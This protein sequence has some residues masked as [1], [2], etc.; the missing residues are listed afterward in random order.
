MIPKAL[1]DVSIEDIKGL[2]GRSEHQRLEFKGWPQGIE[3]P[4]AP[5]RDGGIPDK[6]K[7]YLAEEVCAM[8]NSYGGDIVLGLKEGEGQTRHIAEAL[9]PL[10]AVEKLKKVFEDSLRNLIDPPLSAIDM[11]TIVTGEDGAGVLLIR[12]GR[13]HR[14]P[15][16]VRDGNRYAV[17]V[18]S[19]EGK[20]PVDMREVQDLVIERLSSE[21][22]KRAAFLDIRDA[23]SVLKGSGVDI[24]GIL[25]KGFAVRLVA[26][27][28]EPLSISDI[29]RN[30]AYRIGPGR[31]A[32]VSKGG[33]Q[34]VLADAFNLGGSSW[35]PAY[36]TL[37]WLGKWQYGRA[38]TDFCRKF[39]F[40]GGFEQTASYP[41]RDGKFLDIERFSSGII[42][43][44]I[45]IEHFRTSIDQPDL[46]YSL[47]IYVVLGSDMC[48]GNYERNEIQIYSDFLGPPEPAG[49][50]FPKVVLEFGEYAVRERSS[51]TELF[52]L[53]EE[54][55]CNAAS[56]EWT[57]RFDIDVGQCL[58]NLGR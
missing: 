17:Y 45:A 36:R 23:T 18:K 6:A 3:Y 31:V 44:L 20:R 39:S 55:I 25:D 54:D 56:L 30:P 35:R 9:G 58:A 19:G 22:R 24:Q 13:S 38:R 48:I 41:D 5:W 26:V 2:I 32:V 52:H 42:S 14:R 50:P 8:A 57:P 4:K 29:T 7:K 49:N 15:H 40:N 21:E 1:E 51:F 16:G 47:M 43:A 46:E 33:S 34:I 10:P 28:S 37:K 27:P 53:I 12:I 11:R